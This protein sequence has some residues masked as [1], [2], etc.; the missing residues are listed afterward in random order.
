MR[1]P[2]PWIDRLRANIDASC[3]ELRGLTGGST[4]AWLPTIAEALEDLRDREACIRRALA[5]VPQPG[6]RGEALD[7]GFATLVDLPVADEIEERLLQINSFRI[8][9][10]DLGEICDSLAHCLWLALFMRGHNET[11]TGMAIRVLGQANVQK[12]FKKT[13]DALVA[14]GHGQLTPLRNTLAHYPVRTYASQIVS[15]G[16][17]RPGQRWIFEFGLPDGNESEY[18]R[19]LFG[20]LSKLGERPGGND[21]DFS[22]ATRRDLWAAIS[23]CGRMAVDASDAFVNRIRTLRPAT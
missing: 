9:V 20:P 16:N 13:G 3:T 2:L 10:I 12:V 14:G 6:A 18:Y 21:D 8:T 19:R 15:Q 4:T 17:P 1:V 7:E 5:H 11:D 22:S 23:S